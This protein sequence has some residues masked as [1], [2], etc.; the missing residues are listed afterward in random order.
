MTEKTGGVQQNGLLGSSNPGEKSVEN[1]KVKEKVQHT[2]VG[3]EKGRLILP[4]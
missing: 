1:Q 4:Y 2:N 3:S